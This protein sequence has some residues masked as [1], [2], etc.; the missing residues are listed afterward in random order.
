M[1]P[2]ETII[3]AQA[4]RNGG[5]VSRP[6]LSDYS[7]STVQRRVQSGLLIPATGSSYLVRG[8]QTDT[9][10][11]HA[12]SL[13]YRDGA[14]ARHTTCSLQGLPVKLEPLRFVVPN[15]TSHHVPGLRVHE[16]RHLP[17][18]DVVVMGELRVCSVARGLCDMSATESMQWMRHLTEVALTQRLTTPQALRACASERYR[19]RVRGMTAYV[20]MLGEILDDE[21]FPESMG[22]LLLFQT[23]QAVG[24]HNITRQWMPPWYDG[25]RGIVDAK[26]QLSPTVIELDGRGCRQVTQA[27]NNDRAR[28]RIATRHQHLVVRIG[29][30]ELQRA[31]FRIG[32]E[33]KEILDDRRRRFAVG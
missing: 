20:Q 17:P 19:R 12:A 9:S 18:E 5:A 24:V 33:L 7:R 4:H 25:V 11:L 2:I 26:D 6:M 14:V 15:G 22:E 29:A 13:A 30:G 1:E 32:M 3:M 31:S 10:L 21:P 28:D 23:L 8:M 27:H 16:T